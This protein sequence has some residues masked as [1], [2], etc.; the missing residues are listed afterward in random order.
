MTPRRAAWL[1]AGVAA[2]VYLPALRNSFALDDGTIVE[3]NP[4]AHAV[5]AALDAFGRPYWPP[6]T[7]AGQWRPLV[8]LSFAVDWQLSGGST[9]WLHAAN[10]VWHAA[11]TGLLVLVAAAYLPAA[12]ALAGGVLFAVHPVHV[13]A[14]ANLVGRAEMMAAAFL[15]LAL[16]CAREVR[17]RAAAARPPGRPRCC[18]RWRS[19][20]PC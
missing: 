9:T 20:P 8:I 15:F 4:S 1:A 13:E 5:G 18:S 12:G 7:Q 3:R 10:V 2:L 6:A 17:A 14:V 19:R 16:L 11:A